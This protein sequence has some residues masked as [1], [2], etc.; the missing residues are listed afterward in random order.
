[1]QGYLHR[2]QYEFGGEAF[3]FGVDSE[4]IEGGEKDCRSG[5]SYEI[6]V[7]GIEGI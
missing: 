4:K 6:D 5:R 3:T 7:Q 1:M 2:L